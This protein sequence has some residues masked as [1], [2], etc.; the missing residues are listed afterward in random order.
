M[1]NTFGTWLPGDPRGFRTRGH[2]EH[3]EGDYKSPPQS[4]VYGQRHEAAKGLMKRDAVVL[5]EGARRVVCEEI[6]D[7]LE[8]HGSEVLAVSVCAKHIHV[9][10]R[11][12]LEGKP[13]FGERGFRGGRTSATDDPVRHIMG[14]AKQWSAK[15][16]IA[17]GLAT[18]GGVWAR[19]GKI[20]P[21]NDRAHQVAV[22]KYILE[23]GPKEGAAVWSFRDGDT[24]G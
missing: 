22:F 6:R 10:A 21:I 2:R 8:R 1:A 15:R 5:D 9:L 11:F 12:P 7:S 16:L 14:L 24:D 19:K 20:V 3:V 4:G 17:E 13:A 18:P 23:H